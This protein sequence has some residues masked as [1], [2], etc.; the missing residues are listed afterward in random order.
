MKRLAALI[1]VLF[2]VFI[3]KVYA[4]TFNWALV[5]SQAGEYDQT[6]FP[7]KDSYFFML[8]V[9]QVN[10]DPPTVNPISVTT[11]GIT[12]DI[13][14]QEEW[15]QFWVVLNDPPPGSVWQTTYLFESGP[16]S[17]TL[18]LSGATFRKLSMPEVTISGNTVS[19]NPVDY[20]S[21]YEVWIYP[22]TGDGYPDTSSAPL[23]SGTFEETS[24]TL[25]DTIPDGEYAVRV[26]AREY[27]GNFLINRSSFYK[28][29]S[30]G[31]FKI[32]HVFSQ[33]GEYDQTDFPEESS[34]WNMAIVAEVNTVPPT[35]NPI[36]VTA[37]GVG[38][39]EIPY[40]DGWKC[41]I[42]ILDTPPPGPVWQTT[43]LFE[44]GPD[45]MTL[46]HSGATFRELSIPEVTISGNTVSWN[47]VDYASLYDVEVFPLT[48]DG[49]P[50]T[51]SAPLH[52]SGNLKG[53][54]YTLP[55]TI[56]DGQYAVR[57]HAKE[58][59]AGRLINRSCFYKKI[60]ISTGAFNWAL[61][62]S[63]TVQY[64]QTDF[65]G[66]DSSF[67]M[68]PVA[69]VSADPPTVNP[70][71]VTANGVGTYEMPYQAGWKQFW[72][73]LYDPP[74]G[75]V[76]Q[77]TYLFESGSDST[78]I[79][80][81]GATFR[82]LS[83][84]EVTISGSSV[85]WNPV[86]YASKYEVWVFPLTGDGYPDIS[87]G[88]LHNSG[89]L[90]ETS[91]TLPGT[92]PD[93]QYAV[94]VNAREYYGNFL[95]NRSCFYKKISIG[96][97]KIAYV[98]SQA[99]EYDQTDF[100]GESSFWNMSMAVAVN[101]APPTVNPIS[102]TANG[103][104]TYEIPYLDG[105]KYFILILDAPPPGPV[106]QTTY[107]FESG[108]DSMTLDLSGA[109]FR[110][111][112]IPEVTISGNT[113]SWNPV[114]YASLYRVRLFPLAPDGNPDTSSSPLHDSGNLEETSYTLP[115]TIPDGEYCL[116][117][118]AMEIN[119]GLLI[120]RSYFYKK[121]S[122]GLPATAEV[123][124]KITNTDTGEGLSEAT[125]S[126]DQGEYVLTTASDGTFSS[127]VIPAGTYEV[128][129]SATNY[130]AN[131]L[132]KV[133][134]SADMTNDLS[135]A[136]TPKS[137]EIVSTGANPDEIYNDGA[138]T[139]L[140]TAKVTHPDGSGDISSVVVDLVQIGGSASQE[141]YDD[142][143]H[144]DAVSGDGTY[145]YQTTVA[146]ATP[147]QQFSLNVTASDLYGFKA[148]A[149]INL[150][151]IK[152]IVATAEPEQV[153]THTITNSLS[154]QTLV[155]SFKL[156][157]L[158]TSKYGG[159]QGESECYVELTVYKPDG[160]V[161]GVYNVTESIDISI[162]KAEAG[163][164]EFKTVNK[165]TV[166][167]TY[168]IETKGSGTGMLVGRVTNAYTGLGIVGVTVTCNTGGSTVT[169][170]DGYFSGVAVAGTEAA[171]TSTATGYHTDVQ[172]D[173]AI[174][175]GAATSLTIQMISDASAAQ[176]V[177]SSQQLSVI[178]EPKE[179]PDPLTQPFAAKELQGNLYLNA[180][181]P[182]YQEPVN[183]YVGV[184]PDIP[185][186]AGKIFLFNKNN[187]LVE[188]TDTL[189]PW[190][191]G[192]TASQSSQ[193]LS[194]P[195]S[196]LPA[197]SCIFYSMVT[198]DPVSLSNYDLVS[199]TLSINQATGALPD[200]YELSITN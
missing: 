53:R 11:E 141:M 104:G 140:L 39:Y 74:P 26:N 6:D 52:D 32:A 50:D 96:T 48:G 100:P 107:L 179:D 108:S 63:E 90:E 101:T 72:V 184:S 123:T 56:P 10:E 122:I 177:P 161:Y 148:Y 118:G 120:N 166:S 36:S 7:G 178:N 16:D 174:M 9:A 168:E 153:D 106:W 172:V 83:I 169:L 24:C 57:V 17:M 58:I 138:T 125:V 42:L 23:Q 55:D 70:I 158:K 15:K 87:D 43:Y 84:P 135:S 115:G 105:W 137:P 185:G 119:A 171:V 164:W 103:V 67:H 95:I 160:T 190:R 193:I 165:C 51:S 181:F 78:T 4:D 54:S 97:F 192:V 116:R 34:F 33:A 88:L 13:Y 151:V 111:L 31:T 98:F 167:V 180:L 47:Y 200:S 66:G 12:V 79:D 195:L 35:V 114:D 121:I 117:V 65:P 99:G 159:F 80:L 2:F 41:F 152:K 64:D 157:S 126:F 8:P 197:F 182:L 189:Y 154:N 173:I 143:T 128:E 112:S 62:F 49:Y 60:S 194:C 75:S 28:K 44:S 127:S 76:W 93:G 69:Q 40:W 147:V 37:N 77:T 82:E 91:Y 142:G 170:D 92:I 3:P 124:G 85:S 19:W 86:E 113:V 132:S 188:L 18:D 187:E 59:N 149:N 162:P 155:V 27:Y 163:D 22:L 68:V 94:R 139:T 109:T 199:F 110:E 25:P 146:T 29:I 198:T 21:L 81:S 73:V 133:T 196:L 102:V 71:S 156:D 186:M 191:E 145:S 130:Y 134:L 175:A 45:S 1:F 20:A 136:L 14:Y 183:I 144:G 176:P 30:I 61:V 129:I 38:T 46:D 89:L 5:F 150:K 131:T